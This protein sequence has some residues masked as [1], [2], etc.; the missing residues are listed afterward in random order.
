MGITATTPTMRH[1]GKSI[2]ATDSDTGSGLPD[3]RLHIG[4]MNVRS[5]ILAPMIL[6]TP[7][8]DC[9]LMT[10]VIVVTSSGSEVPIAMIVTE[11]TLS[12]IPIEDAMI[13]PLSTSR[14]AP[15]T[16]ARAP[17]INFMIFETMT[18][19]VLDSGRAFLLCRP[20]QP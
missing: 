14:S 2:M 10:A 9:F 6:P 8:E 3:I 17:S 11:M 18:I 12:L 15:N 20:L 13:L 1:A 19:P 5:M 16:M 4:M 7:S